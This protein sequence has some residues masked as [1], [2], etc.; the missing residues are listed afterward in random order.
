MRGA[1]VLELLS[2]TR[3]WN[4][5]CV[6]SSV[7]MTTSVVVGRTKLLLL[8]ILITSSATPALHA[9][10]STLRACRKTSVAHVTVHRL[11]GI[12]S[13]VIPAELEL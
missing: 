3:A 2:T 13:H 6:T 9:V 8:I 4:E 7:R 1:L 12:S 11:G 5:V 10:W